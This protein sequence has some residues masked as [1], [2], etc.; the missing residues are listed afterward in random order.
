MVSGAIALRVSVCSSLRHTCAGGRSKS[1]C[2]ALIAGPLLL[3]GGR[4]WPA[5]AVA[6]SLHHPQSAP[7]RRTHPSFQRQRQSLVPSA[8]VD[9]SSN[10]GDLTDAIES[11]MQDI[12]ESTQAATKVAHGGVSDNHNSDGSA[13]ADSAAADGNQS[14][15]DSPIS[16]IKGMAD[17]RKTAADQEAEQTVAPPQQWSLVDT[18]VQQLQQRGQAL[19]AKLGVISS[20]SSNGTGGSSSGSGSKADGGE[21]AKSALDKAQQGLQK[22]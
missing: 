16:W 9:G 2:A 12:S 21:Q 3:D 8:A 18:A 6:P 10:G 17:E 7:P 11:A 1:L 13:L 22:V 19:R 15:A 14:S 5:A 20:G 4:A